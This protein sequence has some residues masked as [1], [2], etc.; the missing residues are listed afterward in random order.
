MLSALMCFS[1]IPDTSC[2][3]PNFE[4]A[5]TL[6]L[7]SNPHPSPLT[8]AMLSALT[9]ASSCATRS[10]LSASLSLRRARYRRCDSRLR[11]FSLHHGAFAVT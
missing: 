5:S 8:L 6:T 9:C 4:T 7:N 1:R 2:L 11:S 3:Y 10:S